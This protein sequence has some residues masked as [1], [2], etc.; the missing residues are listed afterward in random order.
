MQVKGIRPTASAAAAAAI[1]SAA[2]LAVILF[3]ADAGQAR[4]G[5]Q[6]KPGGGHKKHHGGGGGGKPKGPIGGSKKGAAARLSRQPIAASGA[7]RGYVLDSPTPDVYPVNVA[8]ENTGPPGSGIED[9]AGLVA[10]GGGSTTFIS[11]GTVGPSEVVDLGRLTGGRVQIAVGANSGVQIKLAY[12]EARRFVGP[13]G[14]VNHGSQGRSDDPSAR[15]DVLP[16]A[17][18]IY[19]LGGIRGAER[20]VRIEVD[21]N[22]S[23]SIDYIR[24]EVNHLRPGRGDYVGHFLSSDQLLNRI[25]YAGAYTLNVDTYGDPNRG[26]RFAVTDGAKHDRLVWLGDLPIE[27]LAGFYTVRQLR[28]Y[29]RRSLQMFTCQ[30]EPG[31]FI[32]QVSE[33]N[34][35]CPQP[36]R[37]NGPPRSAKGICTCVVAQRLPSYTAWFVVGVGEYYRMTA[38][39]RVAKWLPVIERAIGYFQRGVGPRGLFV[40]QPGELNWHPPDQAQ[41]EDADTN[42]VWVRALQSAS[43]LEKQLGNPKRGRR[44]AA[45]ARR[46][47]KAIRIALFDGSVGALHGNTFDPTGDHPQDANVQGVISGV[48]RGGAAG[49]ALNFLGGPLA[50]TY[51]TATGQ[52]NNDPYMGRY[53]SPFESGWELYARFQYYQSG[54]AL[55]LIRRT[56]GQMVNNDPGDTLW[57]K[58]TTAGGVAP[59]QSFNPDGSPIVENANSG[60]TSLAHGWSAGPTAVLSAFVVGM[61]PAG[62]GWSTWLVE[63]QPGDLRYAQGSV[64][65]PHGRLGV[66]WQRDPAGHSFRITVKTPGGAQGTVSVPLLGP[67]RTV[68][69]D[70]R[71]VWKH[72]HAVGGAV[73][74]RAGGYV[75]FAEPQRGTHT[76]AWVG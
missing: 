50:T 42:A 5:H 30:Q 62:P 33:P 31:G 51:G 17:P 55:N 28:P 54:Q 74:R 3:A 19:T 29:L 36:G 39:P 41:G 70:G 24:V 16:S 21:G 72:G 11:T 18:G 2:V 73:A 9:P 38:D 20:Y 1:A 60:E 66:R 14:D 35:N 23:A 61:R 67:D 44:Y 45:T 43:A 76:Y 69:R 48:L 52:F 4:T 8:I 64:G 22:G 49:S 40:T 7:W 37:A 57:E 63:P 32:P 59:Y 15:T 65:T 71:I 26:N 27:S 10:P 53:I 12:S 13:G 25:W 6:H 68:A 34:V 47:S 75:R 58:M 46:L 56:W